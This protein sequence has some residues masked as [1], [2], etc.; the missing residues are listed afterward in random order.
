MTRESEVL[1]FTPPLSRAAQTYA[2]H[3]PRVRTAPSRPR[4]A[5]AAPRRAYTMT[6]SPCPCWSTEGAGS[7]EGSDV[8]VAVGPKVI[9][10]DEECGVRAARCE[11]PR[12]AWFSVPAKFKPI[13]SWDHS[14]RH[15]GAGRC[16]AET[17]MLSRRYSR[18]SDSDPHNTLLSIMAL[19]RDVNSENQQ[20]SSNSPGSFGIRKK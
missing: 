5:A 8:G 6:A 1:R 16:H 17:C 15:R 14:E 12:R 2:R 3:R 11:G 18:Y 10:D 7:Y 13:L 9:E 20:M 19:A 4:A